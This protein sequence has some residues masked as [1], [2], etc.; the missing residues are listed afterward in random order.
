MVPLLFLFS[1]AAAQ[2]ETPGETRAGG[3]TDTERDIS[4]RVRLSASAPSAEGAPARSQGIY[5]SPARSAAFPF[6]AIALKWQADV[7]AGAELRFEVRW[8]SGVRW[9]RWQLA[10]Q[11]GDWPGAE[12]P[13]A[14]NLLMASG[15]FVQYRARLVANDAGALPK[16]HQATLLYIDST[17]GPSSTGVMAQEGDV[18]AARPSIISRSGWG[19]NESYRFDAQGR[20][21]WPPEYAAYRVAV[22]HHTVTQNN[23]PDPAADVRAIYYYHAVELGWGDIGYNFLLDQY[24]RIYEGRYGGDN[25][26]G[27]HAGVYNAGSV[28][29]A[30]LGD[31]SSVAPATAQRDGLVSLLAWECSTH[32]IDP[33]ASQYFVDRVLPNIMG[34]RDCMATA[35]PGDV[36]YSQLPDIRNRVKQAM[37]TPAS[38]YR[39]EWAGHNTSTHVNPGTTVYAD[40]TVKNIGTYTW[41][42]LAQHPGDPNPYRIGYHWF[43]RNGQAYNENP[44]LEYHSNVPNDVAPGGTVTIRTAV[45]VPS[46]LGVYTLKYDMVHEYVT[47]FTQ[48]DAANR[49]LDVSVHVGPDHMVQWV[50]QTTPARVAAGATAKAKVKLQNKG[51]LVWLRS[52]TN[53]FRLGYHWYDSA[54]RLVTESGLDL[55]TLMPR[56]I[57]PNETVE[58]TAAVRAPT[59]PGTYTLKWD[60]VHEYVT[61]FETQGSPTL[62]VTVTVYDADRSFPLGGSEPTP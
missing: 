40:V 33:L 37:Q 23:P 13:Q 62:N 60:M 25:V 18:T 5:V 3:W 24:G 45:K 43:D 34:H 19:A 28:G 31:F 61:W 58:L 30:A 51:A 4:S 55:R 14:S 21:I 16:L 12:P 20:E 57:L 54:G 38:P 26:R 6:N 44:S 56:D 59:K 2:L 1:T 32:S 46:K 27:G 8:S 47:W 53:R 50:S 10:D 22:V 41:R 48:A 11:I 9:S 49:T 39:E 7:P 29:V 36:L 17:R 35:C 42:S 52:G 15:V